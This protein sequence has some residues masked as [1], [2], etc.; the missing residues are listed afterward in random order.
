MEE[1]GGGVQGEM[2]DGTSGLGYEQTLYE[3]ALIGSGDDLLFM[4]E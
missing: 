3:A 4:Y 2:D 1:D